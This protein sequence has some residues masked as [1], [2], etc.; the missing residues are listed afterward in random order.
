MDRHWTERMFIDS[1]HL[2]GAELE[3]RVEQAKEQA[4]G[5]VNIFSEYQVPHGALILDLAC[6]IGRHSVALAELGYRIVG[7]DISPVYIER[8]KVLAEERGVAESCD[9]RIGDMRRVGEALEGFRGRFGAAINMYTSMGYYDEETDE[10][11]LRQLLGLTAAKGVLIIDGSPRDRFIRQW[12]PTYVGEI[13]ED[14]VLFEE[15]KFNL[16]SSRIEN[17]WKFYRK[18]GRDLRHLDTI[19][20]DHRIYSLH[21][22][23][24]MAEDGGWAY[25]ACYGGFEMEPF[26][27]DSRRMILVA[28][29][30]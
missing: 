28:Q 30:S 6:G 29:K 16:E 24:G 18:E 23:K 27:L 11:I 7:V 19:E 14:L 8:A 1:T 4:A 9:F 13:G 10:E 26:M 2:F 15:S 3:E 12:R 17:V 20:T 5:L 21:E 25:R 22:L